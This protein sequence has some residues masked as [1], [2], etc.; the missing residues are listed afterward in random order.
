MILTTIN[1][2]FKPHIKSTD[3]N[4][5][6]TKWLEHGHK[7]ETLEFSDETEKQKYEHYKELLKDTNLLIKNQAY[8]D[9]NFLT[10][11]FH[12]LTRWWRG[13]EKDNWGLKAENAKRENKDEKKNEVVIEMTKIKK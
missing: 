8:K 2:Y 1:S 3:A 9:R 13:E 10:D 11:W 4:D 5:S 12:S 7:L 6:L